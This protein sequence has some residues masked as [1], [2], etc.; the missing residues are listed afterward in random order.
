MKRE[1]LLKAAGYGLIFGIFA[2]SAAA[3]VA[4]T[5]PGSNTPPTCPTSIQGCNVPIN[6]GGTAQT[7]AGNFTATNITATGTLSGAGIYN[8]YNSTWTGYPGA[9]YTL[10][11]GT[12]GDVTSESCSLGGSMYAFQYQA[13]PD[14]CCN[15]F[16]D[17]VVWCH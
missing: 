1:T 5:G 2:L 9:A 15:D 8:S 17:A 16:V 12:G 7:K 13:S 4:W 10:N 6:V 3:V 11:S 14:G